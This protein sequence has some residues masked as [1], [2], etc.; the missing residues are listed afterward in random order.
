MLGLGSIVGKASGALSS[1]IKDGLKLYMPYSSSKEVKFVGKGSTLFDGSNDYIDCGN[2]SSMLDDSVGSICLWVK[3]TA[4]GSIDIIFSGSND[5]DASSDLTI[6]KNASEKLWIFVRDDDSYS[7]QFTSTD[8][9]EQNRWYHIAFVVSSSGNAIYIDGKVA[10]GSYGTGSASTQK[11]FSDVG[12]ADTLLIGSREDSSGVENYY[13]EG[14]LKNIG[15]WG[16]A[17]SA[18][19]VHN[20]MYKT[21]YE[22]SGTL[23]Q[24]IISWWALDD[25]DSYSVTSLSATQAVHILDLAGDNTVISGWASTGA[26]FQTGLYGGL[27]PL[28]PRGVD[29]A[30]IVQA[31]A[32]GTGYAT[33][34]GSS[35]YINVGA[36]IQS[37]FNNSFTLM[38][39]IKSDVGDPST[40]ADTIMG[41][42]N[43]TAE[44]SIYLRL[45]TSQK[46]EL[47]YFG[48][49]DSVSSKTSAIVFAAGETEWTHVVVTVTNPNTGSSTIGNAQILFYID[50]VLTASDEGGGGAAD[51]SE[52]NFE[53]YS[54]SDDFVIGAR[55]DQDGGAV[56]DFWDGKMK[57]VGVWSSALTKV[58]IQSIME[59]TYSELTSSEKTN[60]VSWWGL[61]STEGTN[62]LFV[63]DEHD[64]TVGSNILTGIWSASGNWSPNSDGTIISTTSETNTMMQT[65]LLTD[66]RIYKVSY[67]ANV[68]SGSFKV[69][70][71]LGGT[72]NVITSSG[73]YVEYVKC[74]GSTHFYFDGVS[75]FTGSIS[76]MSVQL[77]N[78]NYGELK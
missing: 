13:W 35:D 33:F 70:V 61:D 54:S 69:Y 7:L 50:G 75:S 42:I 37:T 59:K 17:L 53:A 38:A 8:S 25:I 4:T 14:S 40:T 32:I 41:T 78:G 46:I 16:R 11:W 18:T 23:K 5:G 48:N 19:E 6:A 74:S 76:D 63:K 60:L 56:D 31:D 47:V 64:I 12:G 67:T 65:S 9:L 21:W 58:Q 22:L 52:A 72:G 24:G 45:D 10:G 26:T 1:F 57:N 3:S 36:G 66:A 20:I 68:T 15:V 49:N 2:P 39:W 30:P 62:A 73:D 34:N 29:N 44:D 77:V 71:G 51:I 27:T 55:N 43:S 28:I